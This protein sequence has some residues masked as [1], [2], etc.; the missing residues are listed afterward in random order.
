MSR[1]LLLLGALSLPVVAVEPTLYGRYE[2]IKVEDVG[3]TLKAKMDTGAMTA[4]LSARDIERFQRDGEEWVV[5]EGHRPVRVR[6]LKLEGEDL[7]RSQAGSRVPAERRY[8][9]N[10]EGASQVLDHAVVSP[11]LAKDAA[12][13]ILHVNSDC[14][15]AKRTSDHD[16]ILLRLRPR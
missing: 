14:S 13:E 16:P 9:F 15:D 8:T 1:I 4:S 12:V 11:S 6:Q 2:Q 7:E 10:F 5:V 3:K